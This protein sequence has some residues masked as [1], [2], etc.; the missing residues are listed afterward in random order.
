MTLIYSLAYLVI[1]IGIFFILSPRSQPI[2]W[3]IIKILVQMLITVI[4]IGILKVCL[5]FENGWKKLRG[6]N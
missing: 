2:A 6:S 1:G 4:I 5:V 3:N